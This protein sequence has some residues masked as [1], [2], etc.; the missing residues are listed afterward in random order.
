MNTRLTSAT[1]LIAVIASLL[2][3]A[4]GL[5]SGVQNDLGIQVIPKPSSV[6]TAKGHFVINAETQIIQM[7]ADAKPVA[8]LLRDCIQEAT[9]LNLQA[10][11]AAWFGEPNVIRLMISDTFGYQ[12]PEHYRIDITPSGVDLVACAPAGLMN[13]V[14]TIRQL[15]PIR[16]IVGLPDDL[17]EW[18]LPCVEISDFPRFQWRGLMLDCSRTFQSVEVLK[19][20]IDRMAFYKL[21]VLHLHL[22]D[23][24]GWRIEIKSHP[25][26]TAKGA[27][28]PAKWGEPAAHEGFYT[29]E[30]MKELVAYAAARNI[31]IVPEI[32]M[33][34]H[35]LA[36]LACYPELSC[37]GGPFE[38]HPFFKGPGIHKEIL[39]AGN[40]AVFTFIDEVLGEVCEMFPSKFIHIGGDEAPKAAWKKC[41]KCQKRIKD[42][43]LDNEHELQS[44]FIQQASVML[45]KRG[46]KLI[47]WD[48]ILE[49][50][51]ADGAAVMSWRGMKGGIA[52]A[53]AGHPVV[54]SPTSHCYFDYTYER[55]D[56]RQ[57]FG[58]DPLAGLNE[59]Q[60]GHVLGLQ[61][62]FWSHIDRE[63]E[64][65]DAQLFPRLLGIA[66]RAWAPAESN[67]WADFAWRT[68][69]HL[70]RLDEMKVAYHR[71]ELSRMDA[72]VGKWSPG[73]VT[74]EYKPLV[75]DVSDG[76][77]RAG[78]LVVTFDYQRGSCRLGI[79]EVVLLADGEV[80]SSDRHRGTTGTVDEDNSYKVALKSFKKGTKF[81]L[82]ASVRSEG[83]TDS[84][85]VV[86]LRAN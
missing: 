77:K 71:G 57:A 7:H 19:A 44:W 24:Q 15:L 35:S 11:R 51:L 75:W 33:P 21:N 31:T 10:T 49:G 22:T 82:R 86:H 81:E 9:G 56:T 55:I 70:V 6:K 36:V 40:D 73:T 61:A 67:D 64:K 17:V 65:V 58:F 43:K 76:I 50:G 47:G 28:F 1:Q 68:K 54:M 25:E 84:S 69:I 53:K 18:R 2:L 16:R 26:L 85:G 45:E 52:A 39:C 72:P 60:A 13:G 30:E 20:T 62:N 66:E 59:E 48:E 32:E 80:V 79:E 37:S 5:A 83:G 4:L 38:I 74:E 3:P 78:S 41:A 12:G 42:E 27:K 14:Q 34:G 8:A 23:D 29:Q 46:R 63:P